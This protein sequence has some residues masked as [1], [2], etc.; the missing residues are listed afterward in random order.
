MTAMFIFVSTITKSYLVEVETLRVIAAFTTCFT[1]LKLF[2][3]LRLFE[4]TA[5]YVLLVGETLYDIR[6]FLLLLIAALMMFGIPL[7]MLNGN[8]EEDSELI[9]GTFNFWLADLI[10]N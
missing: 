4:E 8:S 2:D 6:H 3:W 10:Y 9:E 5:F 1:I 7:L